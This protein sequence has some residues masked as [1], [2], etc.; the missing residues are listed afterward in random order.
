MT[1]NHETFK[2][3]QKPLT[4]ASSG[5]FLAKTDSEATFTQF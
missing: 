1:Q 5:K 2:L 3:A 4:K